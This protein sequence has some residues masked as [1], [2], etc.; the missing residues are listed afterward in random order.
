MSAKNCLTREITTEDHDFF[1]FFQPPFHCLR[2]RRCRTRLWSSTC[3][4]S[5]VSYRG[6]PLF[7]SSPPSSVMSTRWIRVPPLFI[8]LLP[9]MEL[10]V[11]PAYDASSPNLM[12]YR[13]CAYCDYLSSCV[14]ETFMSPGLILLA[15]V[16]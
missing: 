5:H 9:Q 14:Q 16:V 7:R 15:S 3:S 12:T 11:P 1:T 2:H 10:S 13:T 6:I 8:L 4:Q